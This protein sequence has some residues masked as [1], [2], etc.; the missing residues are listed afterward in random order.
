MSQN[1]ATRLLVTTAVVELTTGIA[2][3][4]FADHFRSV[5]YA[6]MAPLLPHLSAALLAGGT[7]L[8]MS[9]RY[10]PVLPLQRLLNLLAA[11]PLLMTSY[12]IFGAGGV[13]GGVTYA[14]LAI[15]VAVSGWVAV[16]RMFRVTMGCIETAV[17]LLFLLAPGLFSSPGFRP[18]W[19]YMPAVG[20]LG[21][22]S[23]LLLLLGRGF[24]LQERWRWVEL[25]AAALPALL[26]ATFWNTG[27]WSG[28][29]LWAAL[30]AGLI[31]DWV[32]A[33]RS[34]ERTAEAAWTKDPHEA[35]SAQALQHVESLSWLLVLLV[36]STAALLGG[37]VDRALPNAVAFVLI[38]GGFNLLSRWPLPL[39]LPHR[40]RLHLHLVVL[41]VAISLVATAPIA[42]PLL[43]TILIV[44]LIAARAGGARQGYAMLVAV[45]VLMALSRLNRSGEFPPPPVMA[46][47]E[48]VSMGI[49]G[50]AGVLIARTQ[51]A[52]F[53][54]VAETTQS[55]A[56]K[57]QELQAVNEE[58]SAQQ[59]ELAAQQDELLRQHRTLLDQAREL[60]AQRDELMESEGR[61]R[62]AFENA[63][64]GIALVGLDLV[65][66][67]ANPA[68]HGMLGY[69]PGALTGVS[70]CHMTHPEDL[71]AHRTRMEEVL[72][73]RAE[74]YAVEQRFIHR[75]GGIVWVSASLA[76]VRDAQARPLYFV[77]QIMDV[78][79]RRSA[80][81]QLRRMAN[82]DPLTDL[83]NRRYFQR[84]IHAAL[85]GSDE[86]RG[87]LLFLDFDRFK[88]VNDTMGHLAG[89]D[90]LRGLAQVMLRIIGERGTVARLGG[91]EFGILVPDIDGPGA[92]EL[93]ARLLAAVRTHI[94]FFNDR[95]VGVTVSIGIALYPDHGRTVE[96]LMLHA[97]LAMYQAKHSGRDRY[98]VFSPDGPEA[99]MG[100]WPAWEA[101]IRTALAENRF[102]LV[103]QPILD[104]RRNEVT[105]YEALLR[106]VD[107]DGS[108]IPPAEF[109][110]VAESFG[111]M[112]DIDRWVVRRAVE[113][114]AEQRACGKQITLSVNLSA[115]ALTD[116]DLLEHIR[117]LIHE[118]QIPPGS[119]RFELTESAAVSDPDQAASL[120]Q[121]LTEMGCQFALDD[122]GSGFSSLLYLK[123]LPVRS[124][125]IDG[126]FIS[127]LH[128]D[129]VDQNLVRAI[130]TMARGLGIQTVAEYVG[131]DQALDILRECG[132]DAAQGFHVG[133]PGPLP[134]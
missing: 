24:R 124:L 113:T 123:Q 85:T 62:A 38:V 75:S 105:Q 7:L 29:V 28:V 58:L 53:H 12:L 59:E 22:S 120:I 70:L 74:D 118:H 54:Q 32:P 4:A 126:G 37:G 64:I 111:L 76:T 61:F 49:L 121:A 91:D 88:F 72:A 30:G 26:V 107:R 81:E 112:R 92:K 57:N 17:G 39:T 48:T 27:A 1:T 60:S 89:D 25:Y 106:M 63:P 41:T 86:P 87:A 34:P 100:A 47:V 110:P 9:L 130:V 122:F 6:P 23:G 98:R 128:A 66:L 90:L 67:R 2:M 95:P 8:V 50:V 15:G 83:V 78:T 97:D 36:V 21:L 65:I 55:L 129:P 133:Q 3:F 45:L 116:P 104:L 10:G 68:L 43:P 117:G 33:A 101:R 56:R 134:A 99:G 20:L 93:A 5:L 42:S 102:T 13:T 94:A 82:F 109:L 40:L 119:L 132:V 11:V 18:L 84:Q 127:R 35:W 79:A 125:K 80:E 131:S 44:P 77:A 96:E 31:L 14:I 51:R 52:L 108:L 103:F 46:A 114:I 69:E 16:P 71:P 115:H 73:G 19:P